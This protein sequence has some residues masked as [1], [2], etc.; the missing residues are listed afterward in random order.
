MYD[1]Q[2]NMPLQQPTFTEEAIQQ[3]LTEEAGNVKKASLRLGCHIATIYNYLNKHKPKADKVISF[4]KKTPTDAVDDEP[5]KTTKVL[6]DFNHERRNENLLNWI[7][8]VAN[9]ERRTLEA[10]ILYMLGKEFNKFS[11][12]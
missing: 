5:V 4:V 2:P 9:T 8:I 3:A 12:I 10:Q 1:I 11:S 7:T 6:L